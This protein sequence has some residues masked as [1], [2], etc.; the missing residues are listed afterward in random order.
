MD[1]PSINNNKIIFQYL[2]M[3]YATQVRL[4]VQDFIGFYWVFTS[5]N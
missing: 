3:A 5:L 4:T 2:S 1:R